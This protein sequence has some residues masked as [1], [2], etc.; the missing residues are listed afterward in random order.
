MP[1]STLIHFFFPFAGGGGGVGSLANPSKQKGQGTLN[2]K[3]YTVNPQGLYE[4]SVA[5][6][7]LNPKPCLG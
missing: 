1:C 7:P 2:P 3:P 5:R 4:Y 6:T